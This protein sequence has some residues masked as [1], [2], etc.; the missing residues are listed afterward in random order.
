MSLHR[1]ALWFLLITSEAK[2]YDVDFFPLFLTNPTKG[3]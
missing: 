3:F 1:K 2:I